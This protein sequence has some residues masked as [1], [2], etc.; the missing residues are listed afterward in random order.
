MT[1]FKPHDKL[2]YCVYSQTITSSITYKYQLSM[3]TPK[4]SLNWGFI[5][6]KYVVM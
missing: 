3:Y 4:T 5:D 2:S 6:I 1:S